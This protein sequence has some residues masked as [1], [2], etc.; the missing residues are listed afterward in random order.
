MRCNEATIAKESWRKNYS[1]KD[2]NDVTPTN[3]LNILKITG[4]LKISFPAGVNL[5]IKTIL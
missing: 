2:E 5:N 1:L 3:Q 4:F